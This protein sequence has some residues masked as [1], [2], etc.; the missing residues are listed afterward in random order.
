MQSE[1]PKQMED[2]FRCVNAGFLGSLAGSCLNPIRVG[3]AAKK[4]VLGSYV[5]SWQFGHAVLSARALHKDPV[6]S[7]V[8]DIEGAKCLLKNGRVK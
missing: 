7:L 3:E 5:R 8:Y 6:D 1:G 2:I 4:L